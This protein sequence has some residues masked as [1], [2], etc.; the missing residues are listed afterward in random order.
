M[1][2]CPACLQAAS[3]FYMLIETHGSNAKH[4][5]E[6]LDMFLEVSAAYFTGCRVQG[7]GSGCRGLDVGKSVGVRV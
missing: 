6:K 1:L 4:D 5:T 3:P 2:T 7:V